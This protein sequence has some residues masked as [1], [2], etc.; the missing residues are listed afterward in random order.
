[1]ECQGKMDLDLELVG[2]GSEEILKAVAE[3]GL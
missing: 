1:M 3:M 2:R